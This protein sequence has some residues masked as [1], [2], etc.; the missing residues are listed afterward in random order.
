MLSFLSYW[1]QLF[2]FV[3]PLSVVFVDFLSEFLV[4]IPIIIIIIIII[5]IIIP[6]GFFTSVL[7]DG[8]SLEFEWQQLSS[9]LHDSS[10]DSGRSQ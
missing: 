5:V 10:Q 8:F 6:S 7:A 4:E 1:F 2:S 9:N 3:L